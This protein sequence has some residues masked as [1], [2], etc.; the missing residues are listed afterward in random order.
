[1]FDIVIHT[2]NGALVYAKFTRKL[3]NDTVMANLITKGEE[4]NSKVVKKILKVNNKRAHKFLGHFSENTTCKTAAQLGMVLLR[5]AFSTFKA[6]T[7]GKATECN[8]SK[9]TSGENATIFNGR[10]G[11]DLTN[12]KALEKLQVTISRGSGP[13][14]G[15]FFK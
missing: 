12:I 5:T 14:N 9:E 1:M 10:V 4:D 2:Q 7:I 6:C 13:E 3:S 11:H 8:I 15:H